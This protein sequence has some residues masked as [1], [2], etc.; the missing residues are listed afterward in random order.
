[1][2]TTEPIE[3]YLY[4]PNR[5]VLLNSSDWL[6][7]FVHP[8]WAGYANP[9]KAVQW[10]TIQ[11]DYLAAI[12]SKQVILK[13]VGL[14]SGGEGHLNEESQLAFYQGIEK[15]GVPFFYFEAFDQPWKITEPGFTAIEIHW[16][17]FR[18]NG[19]PKKV[20]QWLD[21]GMVE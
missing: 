10:T 20:A 16:G 3:S 2:T 6:F 7:P 8:L 5:E 17:I 15:S 12:S 19:D 11:H 4:G 18:Q 9:E 13:E 1:M 14:P 21:S